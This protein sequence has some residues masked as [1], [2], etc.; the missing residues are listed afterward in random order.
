MGWTTRNNYQGKRLNNNDLKV[1]FIREEM[2]G[3]KVVAIA[4]RNFGSEIY[5]IREQDNGN[6]YMIVGL[7]KN[8]SNTIGYKTMDESMC[9]YYF[10]APKYMKQLLSDT[11]IEYALKWR[12]QT[13]G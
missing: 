11:D 9:P 7:V 3:C 12:E 13:F 8:T 10:N 1:D 6:R 2:Y 5:C 4:V